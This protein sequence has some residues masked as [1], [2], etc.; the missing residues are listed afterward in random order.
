MLNNRSFRKVKSSDEN[1]TKIA[2]LYSDLEK[3]SQCTY[4]AR[5]LLNCKTTVNDCHWY[6]L[7]TTVPIKENSLWEWLALADF[8][9]N[10]VAVVVYVVRVRLSP[11]DLLF[12]P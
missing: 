9:I 4:E 6:W 5:L 8:H 12:I 1:V 7:G 2:S 11:M 10:H 3:C